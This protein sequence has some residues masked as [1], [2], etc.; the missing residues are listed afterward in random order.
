D[1]VA[2]TLLIDG[3]IRKG[4]QSFRTSGQIILRFEDDLIIEAYNQVGRE[5]NPFE[6]L[7]DGQGGPPLPHPTSGNGVG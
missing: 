1:W 3:V 2:A 5:S 4:G 7:L 6:L